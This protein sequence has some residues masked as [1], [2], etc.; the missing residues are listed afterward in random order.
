MR[1]SQPGYA[2]RMQRAELEYDIH[3]LSPF[4]YSLIQSKINSD[5]ERVESDE[6]FAAGDH[7]ISSTAILCTRRQAESHRFN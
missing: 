4:Q 7:I 5:T 1:V 2:Q 3:L 6:V